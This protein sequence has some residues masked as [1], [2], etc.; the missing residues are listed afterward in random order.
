VELGLP[1]EEGE[2]EGG[3]PARVPGDGVAPGV[4]VAPGGGQLR[5]SW[6]RVRAGSST[7]SSEAVVLTVNAL[8]RDDVALDRDSAG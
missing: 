5:D 8:I 4:G 3:R 1:E 2:Q 6:W 7:L